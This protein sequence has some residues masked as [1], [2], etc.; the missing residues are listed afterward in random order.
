MGFIFHL[1]M[2]T[3]QSFNK[4]YFSLFYCFEIKICFYEVDLTLYFHP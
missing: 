2:T 4:T 1:F 3:L